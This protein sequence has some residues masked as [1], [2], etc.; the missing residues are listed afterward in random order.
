MNSAAI[1]GCAHFA[2]GKCMAIQIDN[3]VEFCER[4]KALG[5]A[6]HNRIRMYG[7]EFDL[8]S[9]PIADEGGFVVEAV[10]R[11]FGNTRKLRIPLSILR[12]IA[13]DGMHSSLNAA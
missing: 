13:R 4:L 3:E 8:I 6:K 11:K 2:E 7:E 5:Y 10:S 9:N 1:V 12:M